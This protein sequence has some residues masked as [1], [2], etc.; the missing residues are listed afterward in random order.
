VPRYLISFDRGWMQFPE[1]DLPD[2]A[3]AA[4]AVVQDAHDAGVFV[5][6]GGI[7]DE[8]PTTLVAVD[9]TVTDGPYPETKE[10]IGG[11]VVVDVPTR[12]D[13][14]AWAAKVAV[15]CRCAQE[16]REF[17]P[18]PNVDEWLTR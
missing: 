7:G 3:K 13:A 16:V 14:V 17:L 10:M 1:A 12:A 5:F 4:R 9:G 2:V 6:A 15:A 18:D 8:D 11:F